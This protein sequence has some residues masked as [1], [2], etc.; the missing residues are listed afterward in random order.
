VNQSSTKTRKPVNCLQADE[1]RA[2]AA[3]LR[4]ALSLHE[5]G[6][7][8]KRAQL[9]RQDRAASEEEIARRL[10]LWLRTRP[11]ATLGDVEAIVTSSG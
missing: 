10:A 4:T 1:L 6:V 3:R 5:S 8:M 7:A 2:L 11:G 9:R